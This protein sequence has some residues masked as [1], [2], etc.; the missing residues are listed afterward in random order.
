MKEYSGKVDMLVSERKQAQE[1]AK[2]EEKTAREQEQERNAYAQL[3]PLALPPVP[4]MQQ[5]QQPGMEMPYQQYGGAA[6]QQPQ[7]YQAQF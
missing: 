1:S 2:Q 4:G 5:P 7:V 3:M 6:P